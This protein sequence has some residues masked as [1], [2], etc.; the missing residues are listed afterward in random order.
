MEVIAAE[1]VVDGAFLM[2]ECVVVDGD[3]EAEEHQ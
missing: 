2:E 3:N 1:N